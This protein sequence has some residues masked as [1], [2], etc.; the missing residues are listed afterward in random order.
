[1]QRMHAAMGDLI[2][3]A[4]AAKAIRPGIDGNDLLWAVGS[5]CHGPNGEEPVYA[6]RMVELLIDGLRYG[7]ST[8][9]DKPPTP[10][11]RRNRKTLA[12]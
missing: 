10:D 1:M 11:A 7:A 4:V 2:E 8:R 9:I 5:L 3:A 6:R 12:K